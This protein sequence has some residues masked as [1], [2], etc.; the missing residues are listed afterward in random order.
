MRSRWVGRPAPA[1]EHV[2]SLIDAG[3]EPK[4][5]HL[6]AQRGVG[7][8]ADAKA[9]L[10]P[11]IGHLHEPLRLR[12]MAEAVE[13]LLEARDRRESVAIIGDYDVDGV[14]ATAILVSVFRAAGLVV[15][16]ILPNRHAG[17]YGPQPAHVAQA[18]ELGCRLIVTADC[19]IRA[20]E[21]LAAAARAG[22]RVIVT[23]HHLP[24][25]APPPAAAIVNP[26][27]HGCDYPFRDLTGAGIALK[28]AAAL[29][30]RLGRE[31]PW[32]SLCRIACL[33]TIAD[34]APLLGENR[35]LARLG[36]AALPST[37]SV[38]LRALL[39][40]AEVSSP[41][42]AQDVGFRLGPRLNAAGRLG[43]ADPALELLLTRDPGRAKALASD[44]GRAN[45]TRRDLERKVVDQCA[46]RF[47][48]GDVPPILVAWSREWNRGVVGIAAG[49]LARQF[50]RPAILFA[51]EGGVAVGSGRSVPEIDLH[52]FLSP[53][54][55]RLARFGG[56]A[57]AVGA[58]AAEESLSELAADWE[59]E[60]AQWPLEDLVPSFAFDSALGLSQ[61]TLD[62]LDRLAKLEPFG[63]ANEEPVFRFGPCRIEGSLRAFG[64]GHASFSVRE[65]EGDGPVADVVAWQWERRGRSPNEL[66][67]PFELLAI[68]EM[69]RYRRR[70]RLRLVDFRPVTP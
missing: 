46:E 70:P 1:P 21:A 35:V 41:I 65:V 68:V 15:H 25:A 42:T 27:Q 34:A 12:G 43:A 22:I 52:R 57:Q 54:E 4:I 67:S 62:L 20:D 18:E 48:R 28:L 61:V 58:T 55:K 40:E 2:D 26:H 45:Q 7:S 63:A 44:L 3:I 17:G 6:L 30:S 32:T 56:H 51:V 8:A 36:L 33:G 53:W 37:P 11:E 60:A 49:R 47:G 38:G 23:D 9:F 5:A 50:H 24:G 13:L 66:A 69:D 31:V 10:E 59:R 39:A 29:L 19:G 64:D 16:A 14:T